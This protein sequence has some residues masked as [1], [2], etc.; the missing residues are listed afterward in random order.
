LQGDHSGVCV[1]RTRGNLLSFGKVSIA[2]VWQREHEQLQSLHLE[3]W[4]RIPL[5]GRLFLVRPGR[6]PERHPSNA[7]KPARRSRS[8]PLRS[9]HKP[10]DLSLS[11]AK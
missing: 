9:K 6:E 3:N 2:P 11:S 5:R 8:Q 7:E 1:L 4:T 10:R